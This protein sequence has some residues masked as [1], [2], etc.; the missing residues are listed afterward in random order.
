MV[1]SGGLQFLQQVWKKIG[2][3]AAVFRHFITENCLSVVAGSKD[4]HGDGSDLQ[5]NTEQNHTDE[6]IWKHVS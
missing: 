2:P 4:K 6:G 3:R 5:S 1:W